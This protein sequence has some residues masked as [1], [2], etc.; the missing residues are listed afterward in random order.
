LTFLKIKN[1]GAAPGIFLGVAARRARGRS[2][3]ISPRAR[4]V[5]RGAFFVGEFLEDCVEFFENE[6]KKF[7]DC[8]DI[9]LCV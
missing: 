3:A 5:L 8:F 7:K 9:G 6:F 1:A 4:G 2:G